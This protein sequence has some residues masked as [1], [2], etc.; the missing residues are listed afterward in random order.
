MRHWSKRN[1]T[2]LGRITIVKSLLIPKFNHLVLS[3]PNP[4]IDFLKDLQKKIYEFVWK[5][6]RDK[7]S[8]DQISNDYADGGLRLIKVDLFFEALKSTWIRRIA[9]GNIDDKEKVL[10]SKITGLDVNDLEKGTNHTLKV[11]KD[12]Q[13]CFWKD[14]LTAWGKIKQKH[15]PITLEDFLKS[16]IWENDLFKIGGKEFNFKKWRNAGIY[17][18]TDLVNERETRFSF[19]HEIESKYDLRINPLEFNS[20]LCSVKSRLKH[21]FQSNVK[22]MSIPR[23]F[24]P[25]HLSLILKDKKGC[26]NICNH[27]L[28][29]RQPKSITK[30]ST[31]LGHDLSENEWKI[32]SLIPFK[33]TLD[34]K[35]RWFQYRLLNR[36]LTTNVFMYYIG[37]RNN[38]LCT[39]CNKESESIIHL[40]L[41]CERVK[42]ILI[43]LQTWITDKLGITATFNKNNILFGLDLRKCNHAINLILILTKFYIYKKR[44]QNS[45]PSFLQLQKEIENYHNLER[46]IYLK[47]FNYQQYRS[48]WQVWKNLFD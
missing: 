46:F 9:S 33:C 36:I 27:L 18:V 10:F 19:R 29:K 45:Y 21:L 41:E 20:V 31:K 48:K 22:V 23:P 16:G 7:I 39:F 13:N 40:F 2:V 5:G 1:L 15:T 11:A 38:D 17:Y 43:Q 26:K 47:E 3:I 12:V 24:I 28:T 8:R 35:F 25:F 42:P 4:S 34:V 6:K 44:C 14:V 32:F 37:Q 30:W